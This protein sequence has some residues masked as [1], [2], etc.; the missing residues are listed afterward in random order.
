VGVAV[1]VA[2]SI[3]GGIIVD[4]LAK[5]DSVRP[6]ADAVWGIFT[7]LLRDQGVAMIGYGAL[8]IVGAWLAGKTATAR[9]IRRGIT[10]VLARRAWGYPALAVI[11]LLVFWWSPT[12][13]T[14][15]LLPSLILIALLVV[16]FEALRAQ[17]M[18]D[19]PDETPEV[20]LARWKARFESLRERIRRRRA[21]PEK[22]QE[23][24]AADV[25][26]EALER[27]GR[28]RDSGVLDG[29]EF[30]REKERI[31]AG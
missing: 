4:E 25:R 31:L 14:S 22:A 5:T 29:D 19:F 23:A 16:G 7:T 18:R 8:I 3:A 11:V 30:R 13:G 28:L 27:L 1:L 26:L 12:E 9:E 20:V 2:R 17:A 21:A 24:V 15:R 10:P 6:A